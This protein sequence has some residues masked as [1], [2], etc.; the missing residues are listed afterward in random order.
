MKV[1]HIKADYTSD[2]AVSKHLIYVMLINSL[3]ICMTNK[4]VIECS[5]GS[6]QWQSTEKLFKNIWR[7]LGPYISLLKSC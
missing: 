2:D 4:L 5:S 6:T 3:K 7:C 1:I